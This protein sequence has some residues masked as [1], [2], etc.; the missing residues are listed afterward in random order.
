VEEEGRE[1][2]REE[3]ELIECSA[4]DGSKFNASIISDLLCVICRKGL[5]LYGMGDS[6]PQGGPQ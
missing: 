1:E 4:S 3:S 6:V 5:E 2:E